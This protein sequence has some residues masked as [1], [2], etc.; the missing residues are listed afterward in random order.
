MQLTKI[1]IAVG[2]LASSGL[3]TPLE[4]RGDEKQCQWVCDHYKPQCDD[5]YKPMYCSKWGDQK[6]C[7]DYSKL[8]QPVNM[9][10]I[11]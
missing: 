8:L 3:A 1:L 6:S 2:L 4:A 9:L 5:K 10:A 11:L 7:S